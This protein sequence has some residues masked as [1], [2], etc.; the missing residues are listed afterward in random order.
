M[1]NKFDNAQLY[2]RLAL[3]A[4]FLLPVLDRMGWLGA[5][6]LNGNSWG[7]WENF[8]AYTHTLMPYM[9]KSLSGIFALLAT[10]S[11][12]LFAVTLI[13]G[14]KTRLAALGSFALTL[15]FGISMFFFA[16]YRSSFSFSVFVDSAASLLLSAIPVY[17][18]SLDN[19]IRAKRA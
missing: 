1:E 12:V 15:T 10:I 17:K 2:L 14:Y 11:E 13:F 4:G 7:N 9:S 16:G 6:G 3:G 5:A 18:W 19:V 8:A